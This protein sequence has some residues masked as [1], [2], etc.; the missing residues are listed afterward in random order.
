MRDLT[1]VSTSREG[2]AMPFSSFMN[3]LKFKS[4]F[5]SARRKEEVVES[6][7][8]CVLGSLFSAG[9]FQAESRYLLGKEV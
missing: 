4:C 9:L 5:S 2:A 3:V 6:E 1:D 8:S 7:R